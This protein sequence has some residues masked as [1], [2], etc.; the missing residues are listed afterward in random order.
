MIT[1]LRLLVFSALLDNFG[2]AKWNVALGL[3]GTLQTA[4]GTIRK[5]QWKERSDDV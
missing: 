3:N 2:R 4:H 1:I 5:K